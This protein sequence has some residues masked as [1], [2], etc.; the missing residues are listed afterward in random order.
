[1]DEYSLDF[2]DPEAKRLVKEMLAAVVDYPD[3]HPNGFS[4]RPAPGGGFR[5]FLGMHGGRPSPIQNPRDLSTNIVNLLIFHRIAGPKIDPQWPNHFHSFTE[6]ALDWQRKYGGPNPDEIRRF[7]GRTIRR[8]PRGT[9]AF[10]DAKAVATEFKVPEEQ[11][12]EQTELLLAKG[13]LESLHMLDTDFGV[14]ALTL[15]D[16]VLWAEKGFPSIHSLSST[17][18]NVT[19]DVAVA[20]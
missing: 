5:Y 8:Q 15:P 6:E 10:F 1:M 16:G 13:L 20:V 14:L 2:L 19:V 17:N 9:F 11:V 4:V 18:I 7:I 12:R 3:I